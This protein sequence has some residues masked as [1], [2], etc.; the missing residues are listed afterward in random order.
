MQC[1]L[2]GR[3]ENNCT[4]DSGFLQVVFMP[5]IRLPPK[6]DGSLAEEVAQE[7]ERL[8]FGNNATV[9]ANVTIRGMTFTGQTR[10]SGPFRRTS[11]SASQPGTFTFEDCHWRDMSL[12]SGLF[13]VYRNLFLHLQNVPIPENSIDIKVFN[14]TAVISQSLMFQDCVFEGLRPSALVVRTCNIGS[15]D[16]IVRAEGG[17][18]GLMYCL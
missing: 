15:F 12:S 1:G 4:I 9:L 11:V 7:N 13:S 14:L 18:A 2:D 16:D 17:C 10:H 8:A 3:N 6:Y 5:N